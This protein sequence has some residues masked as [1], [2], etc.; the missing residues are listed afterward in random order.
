MSESPHG[1]QHDQYKGYADC[2]KSYPITRKHRQWQQWSVQIEPDKKTNATEH[3][4]GAKCNVEGGHET[5][6][7][8]VERR[9]ALTY[10]NNEPYAGASARTPGWASCP[11]TRAQTHVNEIDDVGPAGAA[12]DKVFFG[13]G[14]D[15]IT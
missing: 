8:Q 12:N 14:R 2:Q 3:Q 9:A 11:A 4:G 10:E 7:V 5:A 1:H 13:K 15:Y 6:N